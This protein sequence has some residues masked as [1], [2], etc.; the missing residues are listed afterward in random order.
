[1]GGSKMTNIDWLAVEWVCQ[2]TSLALKTDEKRMVIRRLSPRMLRNDDHFWSQASAAK[3]SAQ[4][5]AERLRMDPRSVQRIQ[6]E[7]P[8]ATRGRCPKC[9]EQVWVLNNGAIEPHANQY[10]DECRDTYE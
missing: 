10:Y 3:L 5:V 1:M 2:G 9:H 6:S 4:V 7:L 8:P